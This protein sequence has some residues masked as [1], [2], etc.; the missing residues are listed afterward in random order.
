MSSGDLDGAEQLLQDA[1]ERMTEALGEAA[2]PRLHAA[3]Q[4]GLVQLAKG[5]IELA[6]ARLREVLQISRD[7]LGDQHPQV[8][9]TISCLAQVSQ[10]KGDNESALVLQ[11]QVWLRVVR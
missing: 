7:A 6:E 9:A 5:E 3:V 2:L 11:Q 4:Y 1:L 8:L 10:A